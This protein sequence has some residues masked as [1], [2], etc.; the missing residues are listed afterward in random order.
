M[1]ELSFLQSEGNLGRTGGVQ[2]T[3]GWVT[4]LPVFG[5]AI[6]GAVAGAV[7]AANSP[8]YGGTTYPTVAR[9]GPSP[10]RK[11]FGVILILG[12]LFFSSSP[13]HLLQ[14]LENRPMG[15]QGGDSADLA[16]R[17]TRRRIRALGST[18]LLRHRS[19]LK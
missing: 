6:G 5:G 4:L 9:S 17:T 15:S 11:T 13:R 3:S 7:T 19:P 10:V 2:K 1:S 8:G 18:T 14:R 12:G 16:R